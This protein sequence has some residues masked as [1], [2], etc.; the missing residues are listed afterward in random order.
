MQR[1]AVQMGTSGCPARAGGSTGSSRVEV[2]S[3][4]AGTV[5]TAVRKQAHELPQL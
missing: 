5:Q 2:S 1:V 4:A 3:R